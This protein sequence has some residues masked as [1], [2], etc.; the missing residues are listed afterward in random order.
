MYSH[1]NMKHH[2][3]SLL[4]QLATDLAV[5]YF[6]HCNTELL[7]AKSAYSNVRQTS[8][9]SLGDSTHRM[10]ESAATKTSN[11]TI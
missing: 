2:C 8:V 4:Q 3:W 5:S 11:E 6:Y 9:P 7:T 1:S 10:Q